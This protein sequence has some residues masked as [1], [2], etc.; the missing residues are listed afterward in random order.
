LQHLLVAEQT[1]M[2]SKTKKDLWFGVYGREYEVNEPA[3]FDD[4]VLPFADMLKAAYPVIKK[5]LEPLMQDSN[6]DLV[7]YFASILQDPPMNWRTIG[8]AFWGRKTPTNLQRFPETAKVLKQIPN[9]LSASFN[10]LEPHS[11]ILPHFGETNA[12]YRIH[13]GIKVPA[14]LP[15]CG[16][17]V[18]DEV[19]P[20]QEGELLVFLD[21]NKH[22]AFNDSDGKRYVLLLDVMR[23][24]F[25]HLK[26]P[27]CIQALAILSMYYVLSK[28]PVSLMKFLAEKQYRFLNWVTAAV[29]LP[30]KLAWYSYWLVMKRRLL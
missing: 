11:K 30:C 26:K 15:E 5:E 10:L 3:F 21:A 12:T 25:A 22:A 20:W 7:P 4:N 2:V 1:L 28:V 27:V 13:L 24:E 18:K 6:T 19:R 17:K 16:F 8:F 14:G 23:P 9:L 29:L